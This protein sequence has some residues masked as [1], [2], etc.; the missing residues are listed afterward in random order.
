VRLAD[1]LDMSVLQKLAEANYRASGMPIGIIDADD[2]AVLVGTG[3]QDICTMYHRR[4]PISAERCRESDDYVRRHASETSPCE[5][6]CKNGLR[7]IGVPIRVG[8]HQVATLFVGQF[9][10]EDES[11][12]RAFFVEQARALGFPES[13]YLAALD[14]VPVF[15]RASVENILAYNTALAQFIADLAEGALHRRRAESQAEFLARLPEENPD[16]ELRL[17]PDGTVLYANPAARAALGALGVGRGRPAPPRIAEYA[18]RALRERQRLRGEVSSGDRSFSM[19]FVAVGDDEVNVYAHDIT[20]RAVVEEALRERDARLRGAMQRLESLLENSPLG[21]IEWSSVDF[22]VA[23]W[24]PGA[25]RIFGWRADEV[26]GKR[27]DEM[28]WVHPDDLPIV[29]QVMKDMVSGRRPRNVGKNRNVRKDGSVIHCEWYNSTVTDAA[30]KLSVL[31]LVL[32]VTKRTRIE[33]ELREASRRKDEFLGMLSH[34]LRNPLAPIRNSLYILDHA[35]P[36]GHQARRAKEVANRQVSHLTRVVDDL[37]D[38]TRIVRGKIEL[39]WGDL[40]VADLARRTGDDYRTVMD[41]GGLEFVT[42]APAEPIW[43]HG[44]ETRLAQVIGNLLQ[45]AAKFTPAGGAVT[46]SVVPTPGAVEVRVRDTGAGIEPG[47]T[48]EIFQPFVQAKQSLARTEG[49]LGL[50]LALVKGLVEMHGGTV[51][52]ASEGRGRGAQFTVRLPL[53]SSARSAR[54]PASPGSRRGSNQRRVLVVDDG[55]DAAESLADLVRMFGHEPEVAFD[56]RSALEKVRANPPDVVLCDL[57][58]PGM[59]GYEFAAAVRAD[60]RLAHVQLVAIS[61]Y[62]EPEDRQRSFA[63]G[64]EDHVAKPPDPAQ[65]ERLLLRGQAPSPTPSPDP[66]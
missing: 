12:D 3:W 66:R 22:R 8:G 25:E 30:G 42:E 31:S 24:S 55:R 33:H 32:D 23:R 40:D 50:G 59:S 29:E 41:E 20:A 60:P 34:E 9:F 37:L 6:T 48:E 36:T 5:Y 15:S 39:R 35:E 13:D 10:Y 61:G 28:G 52:A 64:F 19:S 44:D 62:A 54:G 46:L 47:L 45:N 49:G 18:R 4:N 1:L 56:G 17:G 16:P 58:L 21:V 2:G 38:V 65:V 57:G 27:I 51:A 14:R 11:P 63:A 53:A 7:D 26:V 43:V